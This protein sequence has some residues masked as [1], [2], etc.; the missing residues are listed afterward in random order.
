MCHAPELELEFLKLVGVGE[1]RERE[2]VSVFFVFSE[3]FSLCRARASVRALFCSLSRSLSIKINFSLS[4]TVDLDLHVLDGHAR[5]GDH[6]GPVL[7]AQVGDPRVL[8]LA[9]AD[10][11]GHG[12]PLDVPAPV[13]VDVL[14][15]RALVAL[16]ALVVDD[17]HRPLGRGQGGHADAAADA[18][19]HDAGAAALASVELVVVHRDGDHGA[20]GPRRGGHGVGEVLVEGAGALGVLELEWFFWVFLG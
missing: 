19:V 4:L 12:K 17:A 3:V 7:R 1:E 2:R 14:V 11:A 15:D 6:E 18:A 8:D 9:V 13:A 16:G 5:V 20:S 10:V